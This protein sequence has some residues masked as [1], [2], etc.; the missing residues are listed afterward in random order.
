VSTCYR[1]AGETL[2]LKV[3]VQPRADRDAIVDQQGDAL[4]V[5]LTAPPLDGK[6]NASLVRLIAEAFGVPR[7]RVEIL[8]GHA[9]RD[10]RLG[11]R[12]PRR[13]PPGF[14]PP[15]SETGTR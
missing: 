12:A 4:R 13:L 9:S 10:K 14:C 11:I 8:S 3:R 6:A 15:P 7:S 2:H 5:R 1:W